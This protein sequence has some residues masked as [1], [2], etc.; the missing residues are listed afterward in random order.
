MNIILLRCATRRVK[1]K[2]KRRVKMKQILFYDKANDMKH[3]GILTDEGDI[4]CGCCGG[5]IPRDEIG[6]EDDDHIIIKVYKNWINLDEEICGDDY[7]EEE[8]I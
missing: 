1:M 4:I 7:F 5:L 6:G 2:Q 8:I 3:G